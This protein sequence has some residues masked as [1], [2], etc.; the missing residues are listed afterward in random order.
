[1]IKELKS[2]LGGKFE[3]VVIALLMPWDEYDA[4]ELKRAMKV[5]WMW[6]EFM[7]LFFTDIRCAV[8]VICKATKEL[9]HPSFPWM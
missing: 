2:E 7:G 5:S 9:C 1:M 6:F 4:Y 3:D 8:Q